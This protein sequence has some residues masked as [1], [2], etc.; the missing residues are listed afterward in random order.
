MTA[1]TRKRGA[2]AIISLAPRTAPATGQGSQG[3]VPAGRLQADTRRNPAA[4]ITVT[5]RYPP[6]T[7]RARVTVLDSARCPS[8]IHHI[9]EPSVFGRAQAAG[10]Q[11]HFP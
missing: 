1:A 9:H 10:A 5:S 6:S 4:V 7:R 3:D 11:H 2:A 8:P